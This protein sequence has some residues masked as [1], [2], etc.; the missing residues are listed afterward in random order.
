MNVIETSLQGIDNYSKGARIILKK[1]LSH[2]I[3]SGLVVQQ[4]RKDKSKKIMKKGLPKFLNRIKS[5]MNLNI[6]SEKSFI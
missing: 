1:F 6:Q 5:K 4:L 2:D 3:A